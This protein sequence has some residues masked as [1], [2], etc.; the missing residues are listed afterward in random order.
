MLSQP[1]ESRFTFNY[2]SQQAARVNRHKKH[3]L[4]L[5]RAVCPCTTHTAGTEVLSS[6][7][8]VPFLQSHSPSIAGIRQ[9]ESP[10]RY[11]PPSTTSPAHGQGERGCRAPGPYERHVLHSKARAAGAPPRG[12]PESPARR[13]DPRGLGPLSSRGRPA[14][15]STE[16]W[17]GRFRLV[18]GNSAGCFPFPPKKSFPWRKKSKRTPTR[19]DSRFQSEP[20]ST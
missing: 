1:A 17:A 18:M 16:V 15:L 2:R 19:G 20:G 4:F 5:P 14:S 7:P 8:P 6:V 3:F 9:D 12:Q 10:P 13:R 11:L